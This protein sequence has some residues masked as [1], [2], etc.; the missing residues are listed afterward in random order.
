[1]DYVSLSEVAQL[2]EVSESELLRKHV[3]SVYFLCRRFRLVVHTVPWPSKEGEVLET[4]EKTFCD[5]FI[6]V[7]S[8]KARNMIYREIE[9]IHSVF[10]D[11]LLR[12]FVDG[13]DFSKDES[14]EASR[15]AG[16]EKF[17]VEP[18]LRLD[19]SML[20]L[21]KTSYQHLYKSCDSVSSSEDSG[22]EFDE[23]SSTY[24]KLLDLAMQAWRGV[25][26]SSCNDEFGNVKGGVIKAVIDWLDNH[27]HSDLSNNQKDIIASICN[28]N[29]VGGRPKGKG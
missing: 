14:L 17:S 2:A 12:G 7:P 20:L 19:R 21:E 24:P 18:M 1:M 29:P 28:W 8:E 3:D 6:R 5:D 26:M 9:N 4:S 25:S 22:W 23:N 15:L 13:Y 27:G 11:D 16:Y 10:I